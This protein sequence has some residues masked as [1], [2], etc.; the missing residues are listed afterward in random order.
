MKKTPANHLSNPKAKDRLPNCWN[1]GELEIRQYARSLQRAAETLIGKLKRDENATTDWD[2]C[3]IVLL[4][5]RSLEIYFK[6]LAG[7]GSSF[8]PLHTGPISLSDSHPLPRLAKIVVEI[9]EAVRWESE[10]KCKGISSLADVSALVNEV[11]TFDPFSRAIRFARS[12]DLVSGFY[13]NFDIF[14]FALQRSLIQTCS[15]F[16]RFRTI[17][18]AIRTSG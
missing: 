12:P 9:I 18:P 11:E 5:R 10:F 1:G 13:R 3:P 2:V 8:L 14:N 15:S 6:L 4:Y 17:R 16:K 7:E